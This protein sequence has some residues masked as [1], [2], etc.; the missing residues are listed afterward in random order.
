MVRFQD[1]VEKWLCKQEGNL[2]KEEGRWKRYP[3]AITM[4][5]FLGIEL[6]LFI[7]LIWLV[8]APPTPVEPAQKMTVLGF[9]DFFMSIQLP[10]VYWS[11]I[12]LFLWMTKWT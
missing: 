2:K 10:A 3:R 8:L 1:K 11:V 4:V 5:F 7:G 12:F 9:F 6:A